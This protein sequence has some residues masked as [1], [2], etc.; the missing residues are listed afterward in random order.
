VDVSRINRTTIER[1]VQAVVDDWQRRV[2]GSIDRV[3]QTLRATLSG[4][5]RLE[6]DG[7]R[8]RFEGEAL[9]EGVLASDPALQPL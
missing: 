6:A 1:K 8:Y 4:P 9:L 5:V 2:G 7:R 3:R